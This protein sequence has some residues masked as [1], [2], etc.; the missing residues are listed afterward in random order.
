MVGLPVEHFGFFLLVCYF[1]NFTSEAVTHSLVQF[2]APNQAVGV[3]LV[4]VESTPASFAVPLMDACH[5]LQAWL[6]IMFPFASGVF[7]RV[8][9][10]PAED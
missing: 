8:G 1:I 10:L 3:I 9:P 6:I 2:A 4:Q 7:I 5:A